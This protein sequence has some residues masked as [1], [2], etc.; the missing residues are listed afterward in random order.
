M[1]DTNL[2]LVRDYFRAIEQGADESEL[3]RFFAPEVRQHEYPNR[4]VAEGAERDAAALLAGRR[5]GRQV[6][7]NERYLV[8]S[9]IASG[10]RVAIEMTWTAQLKVP[11]ASTP[12]GGT[13]TANCGVFFRIAGGRIVE[14][15]NY[16]CFDAF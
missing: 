10:D 12:P 16:D 15:H 7:E 2:K 8:R 5:K 1:S 3:S 11:F 4:L 6:V 14:Q 9:A 13:L